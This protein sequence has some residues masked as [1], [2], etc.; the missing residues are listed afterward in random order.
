[1]NIS[2]WGSHQLTVTLLKELHSFSKVSISLIVT[3]SD[4]RRSQRGKTILPTSTKKFAMEHEIPVITPQNL[5]DKDTQTEI[6]DLSEKLNIVCHIVLAYGKI[7]PKKIYES[8]K[9]QSINFHASLLPN[10]RG[11]SPIE[12]AILQQKQQ[13]G[14]TLQKICQKC[15]AGDIIF[16]DPWDIEKYDTKDTLYEKFTSRL[17]YITTSW[18]IQYLTQQYSSTPQIESNATYCFKL[19]TDNRKIFWNNSIEF[20][21]TQY[22]AFANKP[23]VYTFFKQEP[24]Y[25]IIDLN[26]SL[27]NYIHVDSF[28]IGI[29]HYDDDKTIFW[30]VCK[31]G[32]IPVSHIKLS[33]KKLISALDFFNSYYKSRLEPLK[34]E[35][36]IA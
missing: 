23:G 14:W 32:G 21:Y 15:D 31:N 4:K 18:V 26:Y 5:N 7:I 11:P 33:N 20:I 6:I 19:S 1:M 3:Q 8:P 35:S 17:S 30:V 16:Q 12:S 24:A 22:Q 34:F 10:L 29:I 13:T 36:N 25:I 2:I 27:Q 9:Y 28:E